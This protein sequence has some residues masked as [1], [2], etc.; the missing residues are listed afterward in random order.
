[1]PAAAAGVLWCASLI[2]GDAI[3]RA[4]PSLTTALPRALAVNAV[5][6]VAGYAARTVSAS[7]AIAGAV[8]GTTILASTG[9]D[10]W[11]L[12]FATFACAVVTSRMG[13]RRKT[14]LGI[15]E[16]RGGRRGAGNT[17]ANTGVA[18]AAALLSA[19]THSTA[20]A[21]V[22]FVAAL[23]AG[24]SDTIASEIGKAWGRRT[25]L[26]STGRRVA[27]GTSGAMS[28]EGTAAG[29]IGATLLGATGAAFGLIPWLA[30]APVVIAATI[31]ALAESVMGAT[32]EGRGLVDND[33]LNFL[34]TAIAALAAVPLAQVM[35]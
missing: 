4:A 15:A 23:A 28:L 13:L 29:L 1:V 14:S 32:L 34:N 31:G 27:P 18:A 9:W 25:Y 3:A 8:L 24:G 30:L 21:L 35:A 2:T 12:L 17:I 19:L 11:G 6:A 10:G 26:V 16:P 33:M 7:G 22:A 5:V 20:P